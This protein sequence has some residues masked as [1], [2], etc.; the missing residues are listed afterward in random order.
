MTVKLLE[1][2]MILAVRDPRCF[3]VLG[4][5]SNTAKQALKLGDVVGVMMDGL[6]LLIARRQAS[7]NDAN[8]E[9]F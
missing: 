2:L 5:C 3:K 1:S 4:A 6:L 7:T 9:V 8:R